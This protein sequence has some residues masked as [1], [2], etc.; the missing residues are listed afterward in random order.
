VKSGPVDLHIHSDRSSD[1][2]FPPDALARMAAE[3]GFA[4]IAIADHDTVSAYPDALDA[5]RKEGVE[6]IPSMEVTTMFDDREFHCQMAFLD[7]ENPRV[8]TLVGRIAETRWREA[9]ERVANLRALGIDLGGSGSRLAGNGSPG[10]DD[11]PHSPGQAGIAP[12][13]GAE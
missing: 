1:G 13:S 2:D 12:R 4:A 10:R 9:R 8:A 5:G 6:I 11:R 7:W 3:A